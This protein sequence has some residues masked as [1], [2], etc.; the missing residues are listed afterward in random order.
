MLLIVDLVNN[1]DDSFVSLAQSSGEFLVNRRKS[2]FRIDHEQ[3][4]IAFARSF[5]GGMT[6][7]RGQFH[8]ARAKNSAGVPKIERPLRACA[9]C[10][11]PVAR[12]ARL[13][14]NDSNLPADES[15]EQCRFSNVLAPDDRDVRRFVL[16]VH[17]AE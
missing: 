11:K 10:R 1:E 3:K 7:L 14:M 8:F 16:A 13:I 4:K 5:L 17:R 6:H 2:F 15:I 12:Y 9:N